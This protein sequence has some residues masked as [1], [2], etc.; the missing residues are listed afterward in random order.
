VAAK[1]YFAR[2]QVKSIG[3]S[4]VFIHQRAKRHQV[5]HLGRLWQHGAAV[6]VAFNQPGQNDHR[7]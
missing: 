6:E 3:I 1:H 5:G 4:C 2:P 7:A